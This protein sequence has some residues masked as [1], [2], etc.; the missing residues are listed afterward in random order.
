VIRRAIKQAL[1]RRFF[2][3]DLPWWFVVMAF[4]VLRLREL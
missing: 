1:M 2:R 3:G 4:R